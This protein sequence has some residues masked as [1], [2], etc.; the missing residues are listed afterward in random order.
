MLGQSPSMNVSN[1]GITNASA[2]TFATYGFNYG[3]QIQVWAQ[4][5]GAS[6]NGSLSSGSWTAY[7]IAGVNGSLASNSTNTN[8]IFGIMLANNINPLAPK[9]PPVGVN[10]WST[11]A[12]VNLNTGAVETDYLNAFGQIVASS[13][14]ASGLTY[15]LFNL[16]DAQARA[17]ASASPSAVNDVDPTLLMAA[18]CNLSSGLVD[19][20]NYD[21]NGNVT[22]TG[23]AQGMPTLTDA[24]LDTL[25]VTIEQESFGY[26]TQQGSGPVAF[27]IQLLKTDTQYPDNDPDD[28][29]VTTYNYSIGSQL[30]PQTITTILPV[31]STGQNGTGNLF[32][33]TRRITRDCCNTN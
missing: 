29:R 20:T 22:A 6:S 26:T 8:T 9:N 3:S 16:H 15:N 25:P 30:Q 2:L 21:S 33:S 28:D 7:S 27:T 4:G 17:V 23:V 1:S 19:V 10:V 32:I 11:Q 5:T 12:I 24:T 31:I 14:L 18:N 13:T